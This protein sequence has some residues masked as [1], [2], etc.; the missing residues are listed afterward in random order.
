MNKFLIGVGIFL[1]LIIF[2]GVSSYNSLV[3]M[4]VKIDES[5]SQVEVQYQRRFDVIPNLVETVKGVAD[6]EQSTYLAV[7]EARAAWAQAL[8]SGSRAD[9]INATGNV[10]SSLARLLVSVEAYPQLKANEN[11]QTLQAQIEGTENRVA[12]ARRDFNITVTPFNATIRRFPAS[13]IANLFGFEKQA[14]FES[15]AGSEAAPKVNFGTP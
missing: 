14:F 7:T 5:W 11:F 12:V 10:E 2:W 6:F 9:Q 15:E 8:K 4:D 1:L 13:I 3:S